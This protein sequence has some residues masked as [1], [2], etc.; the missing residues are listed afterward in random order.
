MKIYIKLIIVLVLV[1]FTSN[2]FYQSFFNNEIISIR[3]QDE[4]IV[5]AKNLEFKKG[6]VV[7]NDSFY[8]VGNTFLSEGEKMR[9]RINFKEKFSLYDI[10]QSCDIIKKSDNDTL[11]I[12]QNYDTLYFKFYNNYGIKENDLTFKQFIN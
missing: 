6:M 10:K 3:I 7:I 2:I 9:K 1:I 5:R 12:I 8:L 11:T 4:I